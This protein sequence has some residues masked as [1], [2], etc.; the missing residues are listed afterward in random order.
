LLLF[1][2]VLF[3]DFSFISYF[4]FFFPLFRYHINTDEAYWN[5]SEPG[6]NGTHN[7]ECDPGII[8]MTPPPNST[9]WVWGSAAGRT[10]PLLGPSFVSFCMITRA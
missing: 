8:A 6:L 5:F 7:P 1:V 9:L 2:S 3:T 4:L 10:D